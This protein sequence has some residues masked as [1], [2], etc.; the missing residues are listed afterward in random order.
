M[1]PKL[2]HIIW[3]Q[4]IDKIPNKFKYNIN[5][6]KNK[7][8]NY[9][10][11]LWDEKNIGKEFS[12]FHMNKIRS[13]KKMIQ[14]IDYS[15]YVIMYN[16]GGCYVDIDMICNDSLDIYLDQNKINVSLF[17]FTK[18]KIYPIINN[19][20]IACKK[21]NENILKILNECNK[22]ADNDY[23]IHELTVMKTTGPL[24]FN[25]ILINSDD[26]NILNSDIIYE[27]NIQEYGLNNNK[28]KLACH[29]HEFSW[30]NQNLLFFIKLYVIFNQNIDNIVIFIIICLFIYFI[31][32]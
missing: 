14:K 29:L 10:V 26:I 20:F 4:G 19:G 9:T 16:Y 13:Y 17:Y 27:S 30:I 24:L 28:G 22:Y 8:P 7:N 32:K 6:W 15:K 1:I 18:I 2:I 5:S 21:N 11:K 12:N 25:E 23:L 3:W 31:P